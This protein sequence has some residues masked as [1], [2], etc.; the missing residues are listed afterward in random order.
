VAAASGD[1]HDAVIT[2]ASLT[3]LQAMLSCDSCLDVPLQ[4]RV[5]DMVRSRFV[6]A[7]AVAVV[8]AIAGISILMCRNM[9]LGVR[10]TPVKFQH[11]DD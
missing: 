10:A 11:E 5:M 8:T 9:S 6:N 1:I 4:T 3:C 7:I 2:R